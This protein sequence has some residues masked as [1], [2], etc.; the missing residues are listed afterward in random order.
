[1]SQYIT[2]SE[3][4]A[5]YDVGAPASRFRADG[6]CC[7]LAPIIVALDPRK[8]HNGRAAFLAS[9]PE[10]D[11]GEGCAAGGGLQD[12]MKDWGVRSVPQFHFWKNGERVDQMTGS[13]PDALK[14]KI[15]E[16]AAVAA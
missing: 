9:S 3:A 12:L 14:A 13:K 11:G 1:M 7:V 15:A 4:A 10:T 5:L 16:V 2:V 8:C 6:L